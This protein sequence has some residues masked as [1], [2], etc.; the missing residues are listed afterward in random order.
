MFACSAG[1]HVTPGHH[2]CARPAGTSAKTSKFCAPRRSK[3]SFLVGCVSWC[4]RPIFFLAVF[5]LSFRIYSRKSNMAVC[6]FLIYIRN[7]WRGL[8]FFIYLCYIYYIYYIFIY[9]LY[10]Y[11]YVLFISNIILHLII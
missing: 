1:T 8:I 6:K 7:F 5:I 10:I 11:Y 3:N 4:A 9:F 2:A